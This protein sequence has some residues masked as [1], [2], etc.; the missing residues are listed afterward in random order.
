MGQ[1]WRLRAACRI[2]GD[3]PSVDE[4]RAQL[5]LFFPTDDPAREGGP[6][7]DVLARFR[8]AVRICREECVVRHD[9]AT[10]ARETHQF[11]GV[12]GGLHGRQLRL[13]VRGDKRRAN[14]REDG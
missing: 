5:D 7:A 13:W 6:S 3:D 14:S 9:C 1:E 8:E 4:I 2:P 11:E 12:W 10:F